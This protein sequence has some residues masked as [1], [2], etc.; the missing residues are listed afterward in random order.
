MQRQQLAGEQHERKLEDRQL[1]PVRGHRAESRTRA[2]AARQN[3][4]PR[5]PR[6]TSKP[7]GCS[8][9]LEGE[10]REA[11]L[12]LLA[13]SPTTASPSTSCARPS[14]RTGSRC[15]RSSACSRGRRGAAHRGRGRRAGRDRRGLPAAPV[16]GARPGGRR[17][18][19][20]PS[21]PSA[22]SRPRSGCGSSATP[23]FPRTGIL[24]VARLLG[25]TMSQLAAANRR[26]VADAFLQEGDTEYEVATRFAEA[27]RAFMPADRRPA[28]RTRSRLHLREQ[29]R[30]DAFGQ[31]E[32]SSGRAAA[33][34]DVT[35]CFADM[36]D[37]TQ[38]GETL[39]PEA[40]G[41]G[42]R[43]PRRARRGRRRA[44]G[45][46]G[47][48]DRRRGD[49]R[50]PGAR[51]RWSRRRSSWSRPR[52]PRARTSRCCAPGSRP[53]RGA[54][55]R[56]R[57][58]RAPGQ[59]REPDHG[60]RAARTACS[61]SE[62]VHDALADDYAWS[63]AGSRRLKGIDGSVKLWRCRRADRLRRVTRRP[64]RQTS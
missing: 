60:D 54:P 17:P 38:L 16:A 39:D 51:R 18:T 55:P 31:A 5:W 13:S 1:D 25:M 50:R 62:A 59:P 21:T 24:E 28:A 6:S 57:L 22:T 45:A 48:A 56:R 35:V 33:R 19:T 52:A 37:F 8:T 15:C 32:L 2:S 43:A 58:V 3:A 61:P 29:I 10:A 20:R 7:R 40:L 30:H 11:R 26:L 63:F 4:P 53:R 12:R 64:V 47:E 34:D 23:A 44:P 9:G 42:H 49:V 14:R 46:A 27:A 41:D 36:V